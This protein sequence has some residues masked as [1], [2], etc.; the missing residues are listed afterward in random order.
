MKKEH[1]LDLIMIDY[2][3]LMTSTGYNRENEVANLSRG[4]KALA[5]EL[6][7]PVIAVAQL[8]RKPEERKNK[9]PINSDLRESGALEQ[10]ANIIAF[11]YRD[12]YY[13]DDSPLKGTAEIIT[14]KGRSMEIG[15]DCLAWRG[16]FQRFDNLE[17]R[18]DIESVIEQ[19]ENGGKRSVREF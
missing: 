11:V 10:D 9:R 7:I 14:G 8:S 5:K 15:T 6:K 2:I 4:L 17:F 3:Q 1:G 18:P 16:R 13:Y 12:D 19:Q